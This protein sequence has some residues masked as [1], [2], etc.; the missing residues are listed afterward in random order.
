MR[1]P[2]LLKLSLSSVILAIAVSLFVLSDM[3]TAEM[4]K[5]LMDQMSMSEILKATREYCERV[6]QMA[7]HYICLE[8]IIDIEKFSP[9]V[10]L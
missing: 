6:K 5:K 3:L 4:Q 8:K 10:T 1:K 9:S 2:K 7:L